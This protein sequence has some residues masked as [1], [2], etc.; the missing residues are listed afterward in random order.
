MSLT[1]SSKIAYGVIELKL[2]LN[3]KKWALYD[4]ESV[5]LAPPDDDSVPVF[6]TRQRQ[7]SAPAPEPVKQSADDE[8][9]NFAN[10]PRTEANATKTLESIRM[11]TCP[12]P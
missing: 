8:R 4:H 1:I 7:D 9:I 11:A 10:L 6:P 3:K 2:N 12:V 5:D